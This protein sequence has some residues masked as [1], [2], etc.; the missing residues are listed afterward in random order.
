V[1]QVRRSPLSRQRAPHPGELGI[2]T[3][4]GVDPTIEGADDSG[5]G[6]LYF[7]G[8]REIAKPVQKTTDRGLGGDATAFRA[9]DAIG[10]CRDH[11]L[12]RLG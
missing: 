3:A 5:P 4:H 11:L 9:A 10:D 7:H 6:T 2:L 8:F 12:A 1:R